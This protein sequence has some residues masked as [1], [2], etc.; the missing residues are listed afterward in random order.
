MLLKLQENIIY[1]PI[2]SRRLGRSLGINIL[3]PS[4]KYC[5]FN[6]LYCQYGWTDFHWLKNKK[7]MSFPETKKILEAVERTLTSLNPKPAY[8]TFSG[9]GEPTLHP[10]F[11]E[12]VNGVIRL[13]NT[14]SPASKTAILSN[15]TTVL[16]PDIQKALSNLDS[17][18]MKLD[19]GS[20]RMF[21]KYNRP[22]K[23]VKLHSILKGLKQLQNVTIQTL[24]TK[25]ADGNYSKENLNDW[26]QKLKF[27]SPQTVQIYTLD[28]DTPS[29]SLCSLSQEELA[30]INSLLK[31][32][33][34][35]SEYF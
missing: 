19:T 21:L 26:I 15:S 22:A 18:I 17:R 1:G 4:I 16:N 35:A 20:Q 10:N 8:I 29:R 25:G 34:I 33:K 32:E 5:N 7:Q 9:N 23:G 30:D 2:Q 6:C 12:I 3:P 27:I 13:R 14:L 11:H 28:R 24:F 31:K